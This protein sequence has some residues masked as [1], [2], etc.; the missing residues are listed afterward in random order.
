MAKRTVSHVTHDNGQWKVKKENAQRASSVHDTKKE[1]VD[2]AIEQAKQKKPSQV[3]IHK[4]DNTIQEERTYG[5]DP[6]PPDG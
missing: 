2:Q 4:K 1:A 6:H 5:N 3:I